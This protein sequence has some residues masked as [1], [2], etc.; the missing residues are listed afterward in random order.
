MLKYNHLA[1]DDIYL[2][3]G[4]RIVDDAEYGDVCEYE[5]EEL[6]ELEIA[7]YLA[8]RPGAYTG[9]QFR[10]L[11]RQLGLSQEDLA[12]RVG[13]EGQAVARAEKSKD[14]V[15]MA[16]ENVLRVLFLGR[17]YSEMPI[18]RLLNIVER[19]ERPRNARVIFSKTA[20]GWTYVFQNSYKTVGTTSREGGSILGQL[21]EVCR[22]APKLIFGMSLKEN[23]L[24]E[25]VGY[26][27]LLS[28]FKWKTIVGK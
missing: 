6:L 25:D 28:D 12:A 16:F 15:P 8:L 24:Q 11:R 9:V 20:H 26:K 7:K 2:E 22:G 17:F 14:L 4:Y 18:G 1:G 19:K 5:D 23:Q 10:F 3:N 27:P 13:R 21:A